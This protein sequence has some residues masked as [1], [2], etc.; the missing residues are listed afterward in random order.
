MSLA[1][2]DDGIL[3]LA[4]G[5]KI[6]K[7]TGATVKPK[8]ERKFV[9]IP[10]ASEAQAIVART[11]RS[12]AELP[13]PPQQMSAIALVLFYTMWGLADAD[14][15]VALNGSVS[16]DQIKNIKKLEQYRALEG[17]IRSSV[18]AVEANDV[19]NFF[20]Q[21]AR[22]AAE[23]IVDLMDEEGALG[24]A[25]AKD[26]L[27]RAGHRPADVVEHRVSMENALQIEYIRRDPVADVP[28]VEITVLE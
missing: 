13:A 12:V 21:R 28:S 20:E 4:D 2:V 16:I 3:V 7:A 10:S 23:K 6:V 22:D 27:D 5:T 26:V 19:R 9:E 8:K 24:F 11:R 15:S 18:L 25:A 17:D 14:I 1:D